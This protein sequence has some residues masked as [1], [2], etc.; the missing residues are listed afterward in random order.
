MY[1]ER[2][3]VRL[4]LIV[5]IRS[6]R[7][8][9]QDKKSVTETAVETYDNIPSESCSASSQNG[10]ISIITSKCVSL[11]ATCHS[12]LTLY[13]EYMISKGKPVIKVNHD[14]ILNA[15]SCHT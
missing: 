4:A 7:S 3:D 6:R 5:V 10:Y 13:M 12:L 11:P 15:T 14:Q 9:D 2:S 1:V 8:V